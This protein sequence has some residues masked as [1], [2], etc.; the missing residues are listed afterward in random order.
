M[1]A[2]TPESEKRQGTLRFYASIEL[3]RALPIAFFAI[4]TFALLYA[5]IQNSGESSLALL[6]A[7]TV[8]LGGGVWLEWRRGWPRSW[9][10]P[11]CEL[12][13]SGITFWPGRSRRQFLPWD[14]L[15]QVVLDMSDNSL[16]FHTKKHQIYDRSYLLFLKRPP[17]VA[18]GLKSSCGEYLENVLDRYW[19]GENGTALRP[20]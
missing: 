2:Q 14:D 17:Y 8:V 7:S 19:D 10:G 18:G 15:D 6:F 4:V 9:H 12:S 20:A 11:A 1:D 3:K 13:A 16:I 5:A